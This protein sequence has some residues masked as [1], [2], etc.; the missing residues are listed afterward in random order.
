MGEFFLLF[1]RERKGSKRKQN[2]RSIGSRGEVSS[3]ML[4]F[5]YCMAGVYLPPF[6]PSRIFHSSPCG[7]LNAIAYCGGS[8]LPP[9]GI[10]DIVRFAFAILQTKS[11]PQ[12]RTGMPLT[13]PPPRKNLTPYIRPK[14]SGSSRLRALSPRRCHPFLRQPALFRRETYPKSCYQKDLPR[15]SLR[16]YTQFPCRPSRP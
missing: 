5:L 9:Y 3:S 12:K 16:S 15:S 1:F 8:K 10:G 13:A 7:G 6:P 11:R 2:E 14:R 4:F